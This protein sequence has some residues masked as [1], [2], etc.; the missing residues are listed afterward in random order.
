MREFDSWVGL[1]TCSQTL[2]CIRITCATCDQKEKKKTQPPDSDA[3]DL[4]W[5]WGW[6]SPDDSD[7]TK[8]EN[9]SSFSSR[10]AAPKS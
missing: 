8:F 10:N 6:G 3:T 7:G 4:N 5:G 2:M 1:V 9:L